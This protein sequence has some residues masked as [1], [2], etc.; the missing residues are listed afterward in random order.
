MAYSKYMIYPIEHALSSEAP[1]LHLPFAYA[2]WGSKNGRI[3]QR[4]WRKRWGYNTADRTLTSH[5]P[6]AVILYQLKG[7]TR[8]TMYLTATDLMKRET[9]AGGTWSFKTDTYTT[10]TISSITDTA[11]VGSGTAWSTNVA[12]GDY[13]IMDSDH[14]SDSEPDSNWVSIASVTDDTHLTLSSAY[15]K[16]GTAYKIRK[17]YSVPSNERWSWCIIDDKL[18]FTNGNTNVQYWDGGAGYAADLDSTNA[19]KARHCL[20]YAD[21]LFIADYGSTRNPV[22]IAWSANGDITDWTSSDAGSAELQGTEDYITGLGKVGPSL[23]IYRAGSIETWSATGNATSPIYRVNVRRGIGCAAPWSI[24]EADG[25]NYFIGRN[26]FY[27]MRGQY[28]EPIGKNIRDKFFDIMEWTEVEKVWGQNYMLRNEIEWIANTSEG[29]FAFVYNY[30][31][32]EWSVN[33]YVH[34]VCA[35]GIGAI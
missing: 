2:G 12:A 26:D 33:E 18:V 19:V 7:G 6:Y 4:S 34:D 27:M 29:K 16:N 35:A 24:V 22:Q 8:N 25:T 5:T 14:D 10:G 15:T 17:V 23:I 20:E 9:A 21:R 30:K 11:V 3:E 31:N 13:F 32:G 28:P 1:S